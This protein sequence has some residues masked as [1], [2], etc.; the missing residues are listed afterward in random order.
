MRVFVLLLCLPWMLFQL[1]YAQT[2]QWQGDLN[3]EG[4][5]SELFLNG[6]QL[7]GH[8]TVQGYRYQVQAIH[9]NGEA[10]GSLLDQTGTAIPLMLRESGSS[11][12]VQAYNQGESAPP[13][14]FMLNPKGSTSQNANKPAS[15]NLDTALIG[16]WVYSESYTSGDFGGAYQEKAYFYPNGQL[17]IGSA[18]GAGNGGSQVYGNDSAPVSAYRWKIQIQ[19]NGNRHLYVESDGQWQL[20]GRY[21]IE[22]GRMLITKADGSREFWRRQ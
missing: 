16:L 11:L 4:I 20:Y 22:D 3:G 17:G 9:R 13:L 12:L 21:Y 5:V 7:S 15:G 19:N 14:E 10:I 18:V 1:A 2:T 6:E 8:I